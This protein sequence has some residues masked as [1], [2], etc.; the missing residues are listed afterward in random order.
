MQ[1]IYLNQS[2]VAKLF[3]VSV[4]TIRRWRKE[5]RIPQPTP[6]TYK[7]LVWRKRTLLEHIFN[8]SLGD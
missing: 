6:L 4:N 5:G 8:C 1:D 7:T 3:G 2:E